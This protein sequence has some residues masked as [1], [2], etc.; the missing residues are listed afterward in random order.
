MR[1][2][3]YV[4]NYGGYTKS[5][6]I[7][8]QNENRILVNGIKKNLTYIIE[9]EDVITIDNIVI[10]KTDNKYYIY[11]KP[12]GI[13]C[14]NDINIKNNIL[15]AINLPHRVFCLGR[16]DKDSHGLIILTNDGLL[17]NKLMN[18]NN[19]IEK[20]Y[21]VKVKN[22]ITS[23]FI[24]NI[25]KPMIISNKVTKPCKVFKIDNYSFRIILTQGMYRQIRKMVKLNNNFVVDLYRIR[26]GDILLSDLKEG[27]IKEI[28]I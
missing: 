23:D 8:L 21:L 15:N 1:L 25:Q 3:S 5:Q 7:S 10:N 28:S 6:L 13:V 20:E 12:V 14:T 24:K 27:E 2:M 26:I 19:D 18:G 22:E 16:L 11:N 4:K 9:K 17:S